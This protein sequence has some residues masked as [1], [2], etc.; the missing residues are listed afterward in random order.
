MN[1]PAVART[2]DRPNTGPMRDFS[3]SSSFSHSSSAPDQDATD[4][5]IALQGGGSNLISY[6]GATVVLSLR[7]SAPRCHWHWQAGD[8]SS[9]VMHGRRDIVQ[10]KVHFSCE[11]PC[12]RCI[13]DAASARFATS[14]LPG[15]EVEAPSPSL[16]IS[17]TMARAT[18]GVG[19]RFWGLRARRGLGRPLI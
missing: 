12:R 18:A 5:R 13:I 17:R 15:W 10:Q 6:L 19:A 9:P 14:K 8:D 2:S 1:A 3:P 11:T 4:M 7:S 16:I